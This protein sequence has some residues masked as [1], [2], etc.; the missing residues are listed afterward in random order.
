[1]SQVQ[2]LITTIFALTPILI[3]VVLPIVLIARFIF[4]AEWKTSFIIGAIPVI[5]IALYL[6]A[7]MHSAYI[8]KRRERFNFNKEEELV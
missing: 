3:S 1:M 5:F 8:R 4:K 6:Y 2:L 7:A